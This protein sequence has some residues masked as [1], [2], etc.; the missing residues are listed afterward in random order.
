MF[1]KICTRWAA[2]ALGQLET[3][4]GFGSCGGLRTVVRVTHDVKPQLSDDPHHLLGGGLH[5][6][7]RLFPRPGIGSFGICKKVAEPQQKLKMDRKLRSFSE[8]TESSLLE[9]ARAARNM[10]AT[11]SVYFASSCTIQSVTLFCVQVLLKGEATSASS[12]RP[13]KTH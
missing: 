6:C 11:T 4:I 5:E 2:S 12:F 9:C 8:V 13:F 7:L 3:M 10:F 1:T